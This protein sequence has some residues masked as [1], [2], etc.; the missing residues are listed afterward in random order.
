MSSALYLHLKL[1]PNQIRVIEI[2]PGRWK[3]DITCALAVLKLENNANY[4]ALSYVWGIPKETVLISVNGHVFNVTRNLHCALRRLR[5]SKASRTPWVDAICINQYELDERGAQVSIMQDI[6]AKGRE[7]QV[8]L[9]ESRVLEMVPV[10]EHET[11]DD[12]PRDIWHRD[13][14]LIMRTRG[15][16]PVVVSYANPCP[17]SRLMR[18]R[19]IHLEVCRIC[20][21]GTPFSSCRQTLNIWSANIPLP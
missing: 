9:G 2:L 15:Q 14:T 17:N 3:E 20:H 6:Y 13:G 4:E 19:S 8:H 1:Q 10:E 18:L 5:S 12:P 7:E 11:W 21:A 16:A